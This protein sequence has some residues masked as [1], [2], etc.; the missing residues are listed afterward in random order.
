MESAKFAIVAFYLGLNA[1]LFFWLS[2]K[3]IAVRRADQIS[4]GDGG[5]QTLAHRMRA[6]GN[7]GE[8]MPIFFLLLALAAFLETPPLVLHLFG[9]AF[10][11]GRVLHAF[12]FLK[13][14]K[15]LKPRIAGMVLTLFSIAILAI[16]LIAHAVAIMA[17]GY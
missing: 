1:L 5:N 12:W 3:V 8:Y 9:L 6:Q 17:G 11:I 14:S 15:N 2:M 7:A 13:P 16:G 4:I 10:T